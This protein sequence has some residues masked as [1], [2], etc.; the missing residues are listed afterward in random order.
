MSDKSIKIN[1]SFPKTP[2]LCTVFGL[3]THTEHYC[4]ALWRAQTYLQ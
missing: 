2:R 1:H 3:F 4:H